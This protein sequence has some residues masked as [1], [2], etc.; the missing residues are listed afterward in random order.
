MRGYRL[1]T[2]D[3]II[4]GVLLAAGLAGLWNNLQRG[5]MPRQKYI[6][7]YVDNVL[8]DELSLAE[9]DS[10]E[11]P[12]NFGESGRYQAVLEIDGGRVRMQPMDQTLCPRAICSHTG[13]ISHGYESIACL[14]NRILVIFTQAPA[15]PDDVDGVTY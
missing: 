1:Q 11:Y 13:W 7:V 12:F 9:G 3:Y 4:I 8:V 6:A 10:Y 15:S 5:G 14:P 2:L